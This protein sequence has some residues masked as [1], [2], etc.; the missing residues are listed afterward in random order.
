M[1]H[2]NAAQGARPPEVVVK[3]SPAAIVDIRLYTPAINGTTIG[4][5]NQQGAATLDFLKIANAGKIGAKYAAT[6][7]R[8][9]D[10]D[11]ILLNSDDGVLPPAEQGCKRRRAGGFV[12]GQDA[13]LNIKIGGPALPPM[14]ASGGRRPGVGLTA[15]ALSGVRRPPATTPTRTRTRGAAPFRS[16]SPRCS[17]ATSTP[18]NHRYRLQLPAVFTGHLGCPGRPRLAADRPHDRGSRRACTWSGWA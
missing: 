16:T 5:T 15:V 14:D 12:L 13:I 4:T 1:T 6:T 11:R 18:T 2:L 17:A 8:C 7:E 9:A 10:R 3:V